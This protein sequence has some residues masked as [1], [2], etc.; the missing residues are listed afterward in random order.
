MMPGVA[1]KEIRK[2][3]N[4]PKP[5][6]NGIPFPKAQLCKHR[7]DVRTVCRRFKTY[8]ISLEPKLPVNCN[9]ILE[10]PFMKER[11][12]GDLALPEER[13]ELEAEL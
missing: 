13:V 8:S 3:A 6:S 10:W 2:N 4:Q 5:S 11:T 12:A 1:V 7:C 9:L